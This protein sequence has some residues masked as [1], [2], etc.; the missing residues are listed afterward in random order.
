[1]RAFF[2]DP[3]RRA[4][5]A[6]ELVALQTVT[7][8]LNYPKI[9]KVNLTP[10]SRR[11]RIARRSSTG[12]AEGEAQN[13]LLRFVIQNNKFTTSVRTV[14]TKPYASVRRRRREFRRTLDPRDASRPRFNHTGAIYKGRWSPT[15][16]RIPPWNPR[17]PPQPQQISRL[18][19]QVRP[20]LG[21]APTL[22][23]DHRPITPRLAVFK[24]M[25]ALD[26]YLRRTVA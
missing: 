6:G 10:A 17:A 25:L 5:R 15:S 14:T 22:T 11:Y 24:G 16:A 9:R 23:M 3:V 4:V 1:M 8:V 21:I 20:R 2:A 12:P 19:T 7:N 18:T 13:Q 26:L